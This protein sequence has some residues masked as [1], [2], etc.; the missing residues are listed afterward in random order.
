MRHSKFK[1]KQIELWYIQILKDMEEIVEAISFLSQRKKKN[2]L[3][4]V[5]NSKNEKGQVILGDTKVATFCSYVNFLL[6]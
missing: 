6:M 4:Q 2:I 1:E 3:C 5:N